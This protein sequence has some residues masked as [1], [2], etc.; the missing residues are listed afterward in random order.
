MVEIKGPDA[1]AGSNPSFDIPTGMSDPARFATVM[2][3]NIATPTASPNMTLP[4][5]ILTT[6]KIVKP[7]TAP[8]TNPVAISAIIKEKKDL[9]SSSFIEIRR[10]ETARDCVPALPA[11]PVIK[12]IKIAKTE[13]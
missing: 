12:L 3:Q 11:V 5:Q 6:V 8:V 13:A 4:F 9:F 7:V 2:A 1:T 10:T